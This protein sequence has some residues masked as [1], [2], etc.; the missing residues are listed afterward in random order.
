MQG[1]DNEQSVLSERKK[2]EP[3]VP[4]LYREI[5]TKTE[6][7]ALPELYT[8]IRAKRGNRAVPEQIEKVE[9]RVLDYT[10][11]DWVPEWRESRKGAVGAGEEAF[12]CRA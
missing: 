8:K 1:N 3:L 6:D 2:E 11:G 4:E 7:Q 5:G 12:E 9:P 10:E